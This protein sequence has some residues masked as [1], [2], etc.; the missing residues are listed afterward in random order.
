MKAFKEAVKANPLA[1]E[2][3][4]PLI[5]IGVHKADV[6]RLVTASAGRHHSDRYCSRCC[7]AV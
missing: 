3:I 7:G 2:A 5:E 4:G 6:L 1:L